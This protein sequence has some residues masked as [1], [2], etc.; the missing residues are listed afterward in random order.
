MI[1]EDKILQNEDGV[2]IL[3]EI[4]TFEKDYLSI[5]DLENRIYTDTLLKKLPAIDKAHEQFEEWRMREKSCHRFLNYLK[6]N[7]NSSLQVL[8][9][10]AGNGWFSNKI[11]ETSNQYHV[12]AIDMNLNELQQG[13]RVFG[14]KNLK[15]YYANIFDDIFNKDKFE[16]I[17][18]NSVVQYFKNLPDLINRLFELLSNNGTIHILDTPFYKKEATAGAAQRSAVYFQKMGIPEMKNNY[19]HHAWDDLADFNYQIKYNPKSIKNKSKKL[20]GIKDIPF[21]WIEIKK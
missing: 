1:N 21:P 20:L 17:V 5:R 14:K 6:Q 4:T 13:N 2:S 3:S 16:L 11:A 8:D 18:I 15:F 19:F 12:V 10:G 7:Y 9:L